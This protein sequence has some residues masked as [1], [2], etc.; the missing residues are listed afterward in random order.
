MF[1]NKIILITGGTGSWGQELTRQLLEKHNPKEIRIYSRGEEK[2]VSMMHRFNNPKI[3]F[4]LGDVRDKERLD[5]RLQRADIVFHLAALKHVPICE[6]HPFE[7]I[8]TNILGTQNVISSAIKNKVERCIFAT[9]D[10]GVDSLNIYGATKAC[11]EKLVTAANIDSRN[12]T[13]F[14]CFRAGNLL[15]TTG[16]VVPLFKQQIK[17]NNEITLTDK[18]MTRFFMPISETIRLLLK[19]AKKAVGGE[20]FVT[21]MPSLRISDLAEVMIEKLGD[22]ETKMRIIGIRPGEKIH[23]T[24]ISKYEKSRTI[25]EEDYFVITPS[26]KILSIEKKY[27]KEIEGI[28]EEFTSEVAHTLNKEEIKKMLGGDGWLDKD[29]K[30]LLI[31]KLS[32][33]ELRSFSMWKKKQEESLSPSDFDNDDKE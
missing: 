33:K 26:I 4:V 30:D 9:T 29:I 16:S 27:G 28:K 7:A 31:S 3:K 17:L 2:Q 32:E 11:A 24:L 15:G 22:A 12:E 10:K 23:E 25:E 13:V 1:D 6:T 8:Q 14:A 19:C 18:T 21:K 20:I 5:I